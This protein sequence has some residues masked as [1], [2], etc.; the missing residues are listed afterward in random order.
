[1]DTNGKKKEINLYKGT[2]NHKEMKKNK[3]INAIIY[4]VM[5]LNSCCN[6]NLGENY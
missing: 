4:P 2:S 1:M 3:K 6:C 5:V